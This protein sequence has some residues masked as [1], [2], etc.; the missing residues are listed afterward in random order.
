MYCI[1]FSNGLWLGERGSMVP[2]NS[3]RRLEHKSIKWAI[4]AQKQYHTEFS[5]QIYQIDFT[6]SP[7]DCRLVTDSSKEL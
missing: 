7:P 4:K 6:K 5:P 3:I 2:F 1:Q